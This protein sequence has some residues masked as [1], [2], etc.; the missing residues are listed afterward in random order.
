ML[1]AKRVRRA[2][3]SVVRHLARSIWLNAYNPVRCSI[4]MAV[5]WT[6]YFDASGHP[7]AIGSAPA[8]FVSGFVST[9]DK[10]VKFEGYW[11]ALLAEFGITPP[12]HMTE[13]A[14]GQGQYAP[15]KDD[16]ER[17]EAFGLKALRVIKRWTNK[18]FSAGVVIPDFRRLLREYEMPADFPREPYPYCGDQAVQLLKPWVDHCVKDG[19]LRQG[20]DEF[21]IFFEHGDKHRGQLEEV[22]DRK[23][24]ILPLFEKK[25]ALV[26]FQACDFLAWLHRRW[27]TD[28][29]ERGAKNYRPQKLLL[30][31][32]KMFPRDSST[33]GHWDAFVRECEHLGIE[34]RETVP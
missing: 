24:G 8:L 10:W 16:R 12:F 11:L 23:H 14:S 32:T 9:V 7:D 29:G 20:R 28:R 18:P 13:F 15:W 6:V 5:E 19:R 25:Q 22:L 2:R 30:E 26:P 1:T 4:A 21:K 17:R 3:Y 34:K 27:L 33:F 31:F